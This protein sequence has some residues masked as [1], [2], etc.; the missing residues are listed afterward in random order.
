MALDLAHGDHAAR[1]L[2]DDL[3][4]VRVLNA[5]VDEAAAGGDD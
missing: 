2:R 1:D 4:L 5:R 3:E